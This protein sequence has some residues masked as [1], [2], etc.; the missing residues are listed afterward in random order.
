MAF[1]DGPDRIWS[2]SLEAGGVFR[3]SMCEQQHDVDSSA[4]TAMISAATGTWKACRRGVELVFEDDDLLEL[5]VSYNLRHGCLVAD[6][7]ELPDGL[8]Q[9]Y[10]PCSNSKEIAPERSMLIDRMLADASTIAGA[11]A[12]RGVPSGVGTSVPG[13]PRQTRDTA[14]QRNRD[15]GNS[16]SDDS[17]RGKAPIAII[18]DGSD[19]ENEDSPPLVA[20]RGESKSPPLIEADHPVASCIVDQEEDYADDFEDEGSEEG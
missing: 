6:T 8:A 11:D 1:D 18:E 7:S 15:D 3:A 4:E 5:C 12:D 10:S 17:T 19:S 20:L 16:D 9:E 13:F 14:L 2:L